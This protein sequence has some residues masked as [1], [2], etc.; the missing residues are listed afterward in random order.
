MTSSSGNVGDDFRQPELTKNKPV[1]KVSDFNI[2]QKLVKASFF[3][4]KKNEI[5][6]LCEGFGIDESHLRCLIRSAQKEK[7]GY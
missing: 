1:Q 3:N 2:I 4:F 6:K 5:D 7:G